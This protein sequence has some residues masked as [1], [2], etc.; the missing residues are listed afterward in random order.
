MESVHLLRLPG[1]GKKKLNCFFAT[2][3]T[4]QVK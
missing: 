3:S 2:G 1:K 4:R